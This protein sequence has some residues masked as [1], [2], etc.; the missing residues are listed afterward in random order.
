MKISDKEALLRKR[1]SERGSML[2]AYSGGVDSGLLAYL[3]HILLKEKSRCVLLDSPLV[4][5]KAVKEAELIAGDLGLALEIMPA[6]HLESES[7]RKN[8]AERC[9]H[10]K[11]IS[12]RILKE[13]ARELGIGF[14]ADGLNISDTGEH[15][16]GIRAGDEEGIIHPFIEAGISKEDIR[17]IARANRLTFW[18]KPSS[19]CLSSRIPYG[20]EI[21]T[22]KLAMIEK[23]EAFLHQL[24]VRQLRVRSHATVARIEADKEGMDTVFIHRDEVVSALKAIGFTYVALDLKGY[25]SGSMDETHSDNNV[26]GVQ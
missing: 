6:P 18:D 10:C 16:P 20:E 24:G 25:R 5:R 21:T 11:K 17:L 14:I 26:L 2:V 8:P 13:R 22:G 9:Y 12:A 3:A 1:I 4:P 15:R 23:A 19:A 7:F